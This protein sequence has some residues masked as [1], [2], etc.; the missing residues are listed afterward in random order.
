MM[1]KHDSKTTTDHSKIKKWVEERDG[2][3]ALV[4]G[5]GD[6]GKGGG[7]L[8]INFPGGAEDSLENIDWDQFFT[9]FDENDLEFLYQEETKDGGESRFFK[10]VGKD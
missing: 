4:K 8:R 6:S 1:A 10:F 2:K 3:P 5:T 7:L 9:I